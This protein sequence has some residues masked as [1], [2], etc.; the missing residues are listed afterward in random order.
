M[1]SKYL[2]SGL[3]NAGKTSLTKDL[4]DALV[5]SHDG[6]AYPYK[7][8]HAT[9]AT[10]GSTDELIAFV[11][12]KAAAYEERFRE[13]PKTVVFDSASRIFDSLYDSCS[14][15]YTGFAI[16]QQLDKE[17]K[18]FSDF[19]ENALVAN[20]INVVIIS[21]A[22]YD[23]E[24][25]TYSLVG[26]GSFSKLGGFLSTVYEAAFIETKNDKRI[27][28]LRS[29]KFPDRTLQAEFPDSMPVKDFNL[30]EVLDHLT[31]TSV[32]VSEFA[33]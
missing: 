31:E 10:L 26:K 18:K 16:Y 11:E 19:L 7:T 22:I 2:I 17:I 4:K 13:L 8:P 3:A 25:G 28:H 24:E 29:T 1:A 14:I 9:L 15:R 23:S 30:S 21:H 5:I 32:G 20:G 6:K 33:L 27:I 12:A